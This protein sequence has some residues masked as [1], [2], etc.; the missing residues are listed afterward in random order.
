MVRYWQLLPN[1][2]SEYSKKEK[3]QQTVERNSSDSKRN[4]SGTGFWKYF[5]KRL[6]TLPDQNVDHVQCAQQSCAMSYLA[7]ALW[8]GAGLSGEALPPQGLLSYL[9]RGTVGI[10]HN[11]QCK[12]ELV[13]CGP[14]W[15]MREVR[16]EDR[17][18]WDTKSK[19]PNWDFS[20]TG[21]RDVCWNGWA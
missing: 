16:G 8:L 20:Q 13:G 17:G 2:N 18:M 21:N 5:Q 3:P 7:T 4:L 10:H 1:P 11:I 6:K 15:V 19:L 12:H 14:T 9:L